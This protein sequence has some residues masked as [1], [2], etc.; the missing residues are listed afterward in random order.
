MQSG[1]DGV[2][3]TSSLISSCIQNR[4]GLSRTGSVNHIHP[5]DLQGWPY[6]LNSTELLATNNLQA[7][8]Y[9]MIVNNAGNATQ[10]V[11]AF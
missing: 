3:Y 4:N 2:F 6:D 9:I 5:Q 1:G 8:S 10:K 11:I 7:G